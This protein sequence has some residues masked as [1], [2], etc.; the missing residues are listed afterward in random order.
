M[1]IEYAKKDDLSRIMEIYA[2]A[3]QFMAANGNPRQWGATNW[4][5]EELIKKDI[6]SGKCHVCRENGN[7]VGVFFYD[8]GERIE[9]TYDKID[10]KWMGNGAYG[11]VHRIASDGSRKGTGAFCIRWALAQ[12]G[13]LRIDTHG[14]NKVMQSLLEKLGFSYCGIISVKEDNDPRLAY[15]K[16]L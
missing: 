16:V 14:D 7:I 10:G 4:P 8:Y 1:V 2:H 6:Q 9:S 11:V 12:C 15:E 3:R 13:D 5:P